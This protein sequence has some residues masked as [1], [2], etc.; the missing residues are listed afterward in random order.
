M[1]E[2]LPFYWLFTVPVSYLD[3]IDQST[4]L[5]ELKTHLKHDKPFLSAGRTALKIRGSLRKSLDVYS[6]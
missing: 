4:I 1:N 6:L 3:L 5:H 2:W